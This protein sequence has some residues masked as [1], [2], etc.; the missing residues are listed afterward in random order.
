MSLPGSPG[1]RLLDRRAR[2]LT[3]GNWHLA[4]PAVSTISPRKLQESVPR[5][6]DDDVIA[7]RNRPELR[8]DFMI[9]LTLHPA[10]AATASA[11]RSL[12]GTTMPANTG[13][14]YA[15]PN[16]TPAYYLGRPASWWITVH[17]R[18]PQARA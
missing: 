5:S 10:D 3:G 6:P 16:S 9:E 13:S 7:G 11:I 18:R 4:G 12:R 14:P 17:D 2:E 15:R 8:E 1:M